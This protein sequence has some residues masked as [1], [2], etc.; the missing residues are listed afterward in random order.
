MIF[1]K[2][3]NLISCERKRKY[4]SIC[5]EPKVQT[6]V[7]NRLFSNKMTET[8]PTICCNIQTIKYRNVNFTIFDHCGKNLG[9]GLW[10]HFC[11]DH[12]PF[13]IFVV[14]AHDPTK[15]GEA[16]EHLHHIAKQYEFEF[17]SVLLLAT[18]Q[19]LDNVMSR[20]E[21]IEKLDLLNPILNAKINNRLL[22]EVSSLTGKN[23]DIILPW[24][25]SI[26]VNINSN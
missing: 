17:S 7:L 3:K 20:D 23:F 12:I 9:S 24:L 19:D 8:I 26:Q 2:E 25:Y 18:K 21:L 4:V 22:L 5:S 14:D 6:S 11:P 1:S 16:K 15:I 13:M 10:R